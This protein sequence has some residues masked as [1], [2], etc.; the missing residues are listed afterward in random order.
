MPPRD[1]GR[2]AHPYFADADP[3]TLLIEEV[4][5]LWAPIADRDDWS[6]LHA[7]LAAI[8]RMAEAYGTRVAPLDGPAA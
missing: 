3:C 1:A 2:L 7:K 6:V 4:E 5:T 8:D